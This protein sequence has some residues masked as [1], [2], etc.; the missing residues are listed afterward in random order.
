MRLKK[1]GE[2]LSGRG[3]IGT[4]PESEWIAYI[5]TSLEGK[6]TKL[7]SGKY[8]LYNSNEVFIYDDSPV[9]FVFKLERALQ[10][11]PTEY[12]KTLEYKTKFEKVH[13]YAKNVLVYDFFGS[14]M[15][16]KLSKDELRK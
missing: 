9:E 6:L 13:V 10:M 8:A 15:P 11:F 3:W 1:E 14:R 7:S 2:A 12:Y 5:K 16:L 4:E